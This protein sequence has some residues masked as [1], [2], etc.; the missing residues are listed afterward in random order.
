MAWDKIRWKLTLDE[1]EL[2]RINEIAEPFSF[3]I[4]KNSFGLMAHLKHETY[5]YAKRPLHEVE[6]SS[7]K[8]PVGIIIK[9]VKSMRKELGHE[10]VEPVKV[11][12]VPKVSTKQ[13]PKRPEC[14]DHKNILVHDG[15]DVLKCPIEGC[16]KRMRRK[17]KDP[18]EALPP[19]V[20]E[21]ELPSEAHTVTVD[22]PIGSTAT[23]GDLLIT[24]QVDSGHITI[25]R[26]EEELKNLST[27]FADMIEKVNQP[28]SQGAALIPNNMPVRV[29]TEND[30][31]SGVERVYLI[32][33]SRITGRE[34]H[35]DVTS[36]KP[37]FTQDLYT[38]RIDKVTL[39]FG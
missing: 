14:P 5:G 6:L 1:D 17:K 39:F 36:M 18:E 24:T 7:A 35:I 25:V 2:A 3:G 29:Q 26:S 13:A 22:I 15:P 8:D 31:V 21:Q 19:P 30:P 11:E 32:Q 37:V 27:A 4:T 9:D 38:G 33:K 10:Y 16:S 20:V 23:A 12:K 34:V 28:L